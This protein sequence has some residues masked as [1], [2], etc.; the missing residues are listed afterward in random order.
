MSHRPDTMTRIIAIKKAAVVFKDDRDFLIF[1][2]EKRNR[3]I[4]M[5]ADGIKARHGQRTLEATLERA[6]ALYVSEYP[7]VK[8]G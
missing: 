8:N 6:R 2:I 7:E 3:V 1:E 5:L 4:K